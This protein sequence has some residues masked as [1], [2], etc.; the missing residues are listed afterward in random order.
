[1]LGTSC[2][3][4]SYVVY[5]YINKVFIAIIGDL[6]RAAEN[7]L[8]LERRRLQKYKELVERPRDISQ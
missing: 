6:V 8:K 4:A 3:G 5:A 2:F 1:M 7:A